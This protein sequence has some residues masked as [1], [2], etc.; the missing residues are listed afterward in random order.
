M[1]GGTAA[2]VARTEVLVAGSTRGFTDSAW[3]ASRKPSS[4]ITEN[5]RE[6][7]Y[8]LDRW[9]VKWVGNTHDA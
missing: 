5:H 9:I 1:T 4:I 6:R 3:S 2:R 8:S 7:D